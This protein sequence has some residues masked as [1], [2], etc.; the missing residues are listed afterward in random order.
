MGHYDTCR[1]GNCPTCGQA[2]GVI[3]GCG[4]KYCT[5]YHRFLRREGLTEKL[6]KILA[7]IKAETEA[8]GEKRALYIVMRNDIP[9]LNPGKLA[10]QAAH[11]ANA[12]VA[13][14]KKNNPRL[15]KEWE[16]QTRQHFGTTLVFGAAAEWFEE[17]T[18]D[19]LVYDPTYP[20]EIPYEVAMAL[21]DKKLGSC[22]V[23]WSPARRTA[24]FLRKELVGAFFL[25][26]EKPLKLQG[27]DLYP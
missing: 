13:F 18:D 5:T 24:A 20:C 27:L 12:A 19:H 6:D 9:S 10:A 8:A 11:V 2:L 21:V 7:E 1:E 4:R 15:L 3:W 16:G 14:Y 25:S 17:I 23:A 26:N 22:Q